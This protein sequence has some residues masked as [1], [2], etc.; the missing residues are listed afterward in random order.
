MAIEGVNPG[1]REAPIA[2]S[3]SQNSLTQGE[4]ELQVKEGKPPMEVTAADQPP[5]QWRKEEDLQE[6]WRRRVSRKR[7][8]N[9]SK[10]KEE[11]Q[12]TGEALELENHLE[13]ETGTRV[14]VRS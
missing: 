2:N 4:E 1:Y 7:Q 6:K 12:E 5:V 9:A 10:I 8:G 13:E 11:A 3:T 14:D